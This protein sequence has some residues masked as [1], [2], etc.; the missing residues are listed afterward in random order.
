MQAD[1][2]TWDP[3]TSTNGQA[4][5]APY[6]AQLW[7]GNYATDPSSGIFKPG[8]YRTNMPPVG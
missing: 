1:I 2:T 6:L 7:Y 8:G 3:Y 5:Y 4:G